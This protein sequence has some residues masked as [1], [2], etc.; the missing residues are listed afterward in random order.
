[1]DKEKQSL[2]KRFMNDERTSQT[3][4]DIILKSFLK[5]R[6][7][8]DVNFLAASR[9]AIDLLDEAWRE[10]SKYKSELEQDSNVSVQVGL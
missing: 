10:L 6:R 7:Q 2:V 5:P 9:I 8:A 1:M 4:Y 3:V